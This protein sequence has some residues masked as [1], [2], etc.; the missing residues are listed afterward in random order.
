MIQG[1]AD[2]DLTP[3][4]VGKFINCYFR[5]QSPK[6]DLFTLDPWG[7]GDG[8]NFS[9]SIRLT[10]E[11][12]EKLSLDLLQTVKILLDN[13]C[14]VHGSWNE[15][16]IPAER[17]YGQKDRMHDYILIGY[18]EMGIFYSVG[19]TKSG[20]YEEVTVTFEEYLDSLRHST[21]RCL[22]LNT[23]QFCANG[24]FCFLGKEYLTA[25]RA[26]NQLY[27][28]SIK[29]AMTQKRK[30]C[31]QSVDALIPFWQWKKPYCRHS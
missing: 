7:E 1:N 29:Y 12:F 10:R 28:L 31:L 23:C 30:Y 26:A 9:Q 6:F 22:D 2:F 19:Y 20:R 25:S 14:R 21:N 13:G 17:V 11:M 15:K 16:Y 3:W 18:E 24:N 27:M 8:V 5:L 4:I